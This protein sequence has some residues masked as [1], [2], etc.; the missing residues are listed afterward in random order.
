M[1]KQERIK[2]A[3][4]TFSI[5]AGIAGLLLPQTGMDI[6]VFSGLAFLL[7]FYIARQCGSDE[8][9]SVKNIF[10]LTTSIIGANLAGAAAATAVSAV[11]RFIPFVGNVAIAAIYFIAMQT[12]GWTAFFY[13]DQ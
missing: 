4:V 12:I 10:A 11:G 8:D 2:R 9:Y 1:D 3:I 13:F 7:V 5:A 6:P